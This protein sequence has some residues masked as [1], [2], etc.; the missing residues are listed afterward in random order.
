[1]IGFQRSYYRSLSLF[2]EK[3]KADLLTDNLG[4]KLEDC[5]SFDVIASLFAEAEGMDGLIKYSIP[6]PSYCCP[7]IT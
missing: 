6:T 7:V 3:A 1:M 2:D 4:A 5:D